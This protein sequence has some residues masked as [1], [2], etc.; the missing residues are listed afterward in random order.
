[1]KVLQAQ[2]A[3]RFPRQNRQ[4][5]RSRTCR[6]SRHQ[7]HIEGLQVGSTNLLSTHQRHSHTKKAVINRC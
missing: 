5:G 4:G 6:V 7:G 3:V 1:M 2:P